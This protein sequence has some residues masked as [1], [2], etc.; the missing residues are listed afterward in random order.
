MTW[1]NDLEDLGTKGI[2]KAK[3]MYALEN[4]SDINAVGSIAIPIKGTIPGRYAQQYILNTGSINNV[5]YR[6]RGDL[7]YGHENSIAA[8]FNPLKPY[9]GNEKAKSFIGIRNG[10]LV[11]GNK[12]TFK[13]GDLISPTV[14][15]TITSVANY[16]AKRN[17][18]NPD[19]Y[20]PVV[21]MFGGGTGSLNILAGTKPG[22]GMDKY[23]DISGG[24]VLLEANGQTEIAY[25]S[26]NHVIDAINKFKKNA[27][28]DTVKVYSLDNGSYSNALQKDGL[29]SPED[30]RAYDNLN[31]GGGN[32][33][34]ARKDNGGKKSF[35]NVIK[36][37]AN[38]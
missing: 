24:G 6:N 26:T 21:N 13:D 32:F 12:S 7:S 1:L 4:P 31:N 11:V 19:Y 36:A 35:A 29:I 27:K 30:L 5:G 17:N 28:S 3:R 22:E 2:N 34:Y 38:K 33:L 37:G 25:G 16:T 20:V 23:G 8:L 14:A 18:D 15:N 10:K 9:A